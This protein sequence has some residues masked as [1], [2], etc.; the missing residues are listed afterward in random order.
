VVVEG[1]IAAEQQQQLVED[2]QQQEAQLD[3]SSRPGGE[4][5]QQG[6]QRIKHPVFLSGAGHHF[7]LVLGSSKVGK[8]NQEAGGVAMAA[9][10][11]KDR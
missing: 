6:A 7:L 9:P 2:Q 8:K 1:A 10:A 11:G 5:Q 3:G 4:E